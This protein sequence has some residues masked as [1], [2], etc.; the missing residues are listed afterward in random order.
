MKV[1]YVIKAKVAGPRSKGLGVQGG[2]EEE[3]AE[4]K[5]WPSNKSSSRL[6]QRHQ[7]AGDHDA[8]SAG[9]SSEPSG[10]RLV[11][12]Q[13]LNSQNETETLSKQ[14]ELVSVCMWGAQ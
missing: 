4:A 10:L 1:L 5:R 12:L 11:L 9:T 2:E 14:I 8:P 7:S 3:G 13:R 6:H